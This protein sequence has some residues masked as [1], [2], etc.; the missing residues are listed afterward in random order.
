MTI[1]KNGWF[2]DLEIQEIY[3]QIYRQTHHQ[4]PNTVTETLN[5]GKPENPNETHDNYLCTVNIQ[6]QT[7]IQEEKNNI[8]HYK[9]EVWKENRF[10]FS[11]E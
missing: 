11:Q 8:Y 7:R 10:A 5:T 4:I 9:N 3:E 1:T 2:S 6:T